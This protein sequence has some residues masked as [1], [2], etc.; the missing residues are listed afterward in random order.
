[1]TPTKQT[2]KPKDPRDKPPAGLPD[3]VG[4]PSQNQ[5]LQSDREWVKLNNKL[6]KTG[7]RNE[8]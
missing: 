4:L 5:F 3:G 8:R 2:D 1:M 6:K 7:K